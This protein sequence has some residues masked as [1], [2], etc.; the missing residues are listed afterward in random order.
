MRIKRC[1]VIKDALSTKDNKGTLC[2]QRDAIS[3]KRETCSQEE[4]KGRALL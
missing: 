2:E 1:A 3:T 4:E